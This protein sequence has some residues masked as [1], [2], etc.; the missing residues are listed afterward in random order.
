MM[1]RGLFFRRCVLA[2]IFRDGRTNKAGILDLTNVSS[3][4]P[5]ELGKERPFCWQAALFA[6]SC[7]GIARNTLE[8][9]IYFEERAVQENDVLHTWR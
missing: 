7:I 5:E 1:R 4:N 6:C 3:Y 2:G 8:I 9:E